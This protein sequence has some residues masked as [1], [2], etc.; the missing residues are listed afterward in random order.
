MDFNTLSKRRMQ[1][2]TGRGNA[3]FKNIL[4]Q[5]SVIADSGEDYQGVLKS[6]GQKFLGRPRTGKAILRK[7]NKA[8]SITFPGFRHTTKLKQSKRHG[9]GTKTDVQINETE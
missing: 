7:K 1:N 9:T 5:I 2:N 4:L 6:L 8:G 3:R